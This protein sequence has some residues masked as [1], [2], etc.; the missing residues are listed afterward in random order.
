M[1]VLIVIV[2][3]FCCRN[4][5]HSFETWLSCPANLAL[6]VF[7]ALRRHPCLCCNGV[8]ASI[9]LLMPALHWHCHQRCTGLF[10]LIALALPPALQTSVSPTKTQSQHIHVHGV[11]VVVIILARGLIAVPGIVP[12]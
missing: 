9:A 6:V 5:R 11:I 2:C 8:L 4:W 7:L 1:I 12:R 3:S 10:A